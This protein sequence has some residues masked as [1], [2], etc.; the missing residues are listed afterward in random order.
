MSLSLKIINEINDEIVFLRKISKKDKNFLFNSLN[1]ENITKYLLI[2]PLLSLNHSKLLIKKYFKDWVDNKQFCY[3][4][5]IN[6]RGIRK[7]IGIINLWN[8]NWRSKRAEIGIWI[9]SKFWGNGYGNSAVNLLII[10]ALEYLNLHRLEVHI[11]RDNNFSIN[12]FMKC[13]FIQ[14]TLLKDYLFINGIFHDAIYL[15]LI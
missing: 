4:I 1:D 8:I 7:Q 11:A 6:D 12:L 5:E 2:G 3:I 14:E 15:S 13:G 9:I 10:I